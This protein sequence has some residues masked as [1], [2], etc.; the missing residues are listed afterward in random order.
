[1]VDNVDSATRSR[2]MSKIKSR[3]T[4]P[5]L[6]VRRLL[7]AA[8]FRFRIHRKDLPGKPD[9]VLPKYKAVIFIH[10]C[11]WHGH[12]GCKLFRIPTT[13]TEF[14]ENKICKNQLNDTRALQLLLDQGWR[15]CNIWECVIRK[16]RKDPENILDTIS[17]W[18]HSGE[19]LLEVNEEL[20]VFNQLKN[21]K[22]S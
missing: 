22:T 7:H 9:I 19:P 8:G 6:M 2:I 15:V 20:L 13:R 4:Q 17:K 21:N 1:M 5:E 11:F 16:Y 3:D 14:W 10:G 12:T 18:L